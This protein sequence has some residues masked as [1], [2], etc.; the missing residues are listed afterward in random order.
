MLQICNW[1][2]NWRR[3]L[4]NTSSERNKKTWAYLIKTYNNT[5]RG[6]V[7][8]F[9]ICSEDSIW[10]ETDPASPDSVANKP[11]HCYSSACP[12]ISIGNYNDKPQ[13]VQ[14]KPQCYRVSSTTEN[15]NFYS[16]SSVQSINKYKSHIM[17][18]Y[19]KGLGTKE[20]NASKMSDTGDQPIL[21][22][23]WLE[24]AAKFQPRQSN[25]VAWVTSSNGKFRSNTIGQGK[26]SDFSSDCF[27]SSKTKSSYEK[28]FDY[29]NESSNVIY[30]HGQEE[31]E[32]AVALTRL[33]GLFRS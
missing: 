28:A 29:R 18:K 1:F 17:E 30:I 7:E 3:K 11:D 14:V 27:D 15:R 22:T 8:Q 33:A 21:L 24:S 10:E 9:S 13:N 16:D 26:M 2:A 25:Y 6:N 31:V 19:L 5:A 12:E 4:K 20:L 23:K 32:A